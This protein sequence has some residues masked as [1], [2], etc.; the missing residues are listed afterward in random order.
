MCVPGCPI[1]PENLS[2]TLAYPLYQLVGQAPMIPLDEQLRPQW[3][4]NATHRARGLRPG[5]LL[6]AGAVRQG[7]RVARVPRQARLL[8]LVVPCNAVQRANRVDLLPYLDFDLDLLEANVAR[9][10]PSARIVRVSARTGEGLD[11]WYRC[12]TREGGVCR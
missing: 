7:L 4:F 5:R 12:L 9:V 8:G 6:L 10:N 3:L 11:D 2:E 1:Q